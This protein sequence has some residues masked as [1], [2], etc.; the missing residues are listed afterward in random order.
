MAK[1]NP[2]LTEDS[3]T[4]LSRPITPAEGADLSNKNKKAM[5]SMYKYMETSG[6][7]EGFK[8]ENPKAHAALKKAYGE[9][10]KSAAK[11]AA[12][13]VAKAAAKPAAKAPA[14]PAAKPTAKKA[15]P[16]KKK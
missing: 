6:T 1:N 12:K 7:L 15:A 2:I 9:P 10:A 8:K 16:A 3:K 11:S 14:K 4:G 5:S 13:P